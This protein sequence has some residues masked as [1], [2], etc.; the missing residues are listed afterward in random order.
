MKLAHNAIRNNLLA[1]LSPQD[2]ALLADS[3]Q[4]VDFTTGQSLFHPGQD[5]R[6]VFFPGPGTIASLVIGARDG[7]TTEAALIGTEGAVGGVI[8]EGFK[9]AFAHG[10]IQI[11]GPGYRLPIAVLSRAKKQ[12]PTLRDH[13]A[14]YADCL[15]AQILQSVACNTIHEFD[16]RL[17]RWLLA[18]QDRIGSDKL[19]VTQE[20]IA[21]MLG[22]Q[23][24]YTTRVIK[25]LVE[26]GTIT[27]G[28][29]VVTIVSRARL[30]RESCE[31]YAYLQR[32]F[33]RVMPD[34]Y[35]V[36]QK[37]KR[38]AKSDA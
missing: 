20:F 15:I 30:E 34:I 32:H 4:S 10:V 3:L 5:V 2:C 11:G 36:Y 13:F 12:S 6:Y 35:P 27:N 8:S 1:T 28:P 26:A 14:R 18:V 21:N 16:A 19:H 9:P 37:P 17:A 38:A 7:V 24:T 22:V 31:C 29:G 23:R 33:Q 25:R